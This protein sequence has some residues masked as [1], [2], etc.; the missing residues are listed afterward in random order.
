MTYYKFILNVFKAG[1]C[2][3][4]CKE[5][6]ILLTRYH[7]LLSER[8]AAQLKWSRCINTKGFRGCNVLCDLHLE[9]LNCRLKGIIQGLHSNITPKALS[10]AAH[11]VGIVHK[12]CDIVST[13][14]GLHKESGNHTRPSFTKEC[15][16]M[17]KQLMEQK[18]FTSMGRKPAAY[19]YIKNILQLFHT[20]NEAMDN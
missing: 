8:Q 2:F 15:S 18:V 17:V 10:R 11:S 3:N 1:C 19:K 5:V 14:S 16:Q 9:H 4:Y 13:K 12:V 20:K 7:C 6:V